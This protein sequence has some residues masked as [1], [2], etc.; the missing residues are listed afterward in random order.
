[1]GDELRSELRSEMRSLNADT[2]T[3]MRVLHE[4][5]I[6]RFELLDEHAGRNRSNA[7]RRRKP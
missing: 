6:K 7:P 4:D 5:V 1:M 3:Q 2:L